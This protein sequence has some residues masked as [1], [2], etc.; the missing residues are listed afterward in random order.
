[1]PVRNCPLSNLGIEQSKKL[2]L[3]FDMLILSPLKR[4]IQT[5]ANSNIKTKQLIISPYIREHISWE[6]N[7]LD[8]EHNVPAESIED[9]H[10]RIKYVMNMIHS[11][12]YQNIGI[13]SHSEFLHELFLLEFK[14][15]IFFQNSNFVTV[16]L[17]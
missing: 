2:N 16:K 14:Q 4:A 12:P 7:W 6:S 13:I 11:M 10:K 17:N 5:Y 9:M 3:Q 1:M 8:F 15:N